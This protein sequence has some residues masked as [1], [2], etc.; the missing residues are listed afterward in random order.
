[1]YIS[2]L[3]TN[4]LGKVMP[5][6]CSKRYCLLITEFIGLKVLNVMTLA[7]CHVEHEYDWY[8]HLHQTMGK[9]GDSTQQLFRRVHKHL[10]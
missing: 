5:L 1:M 3:F 9:K 10:T 2:M 8:T 7:D 6:P 4:E